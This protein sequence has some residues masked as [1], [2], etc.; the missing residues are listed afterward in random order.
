MIVY[1]ICVVV[2]N[3]VNLFIILSAFNCLH[4]FT[5]W[6]TNFLRHFEVRVGETAVEDDPSKVNELCSKFTANAEKYSEVSLKCAYPGIEGNVISV[7]ASNYNFAVLEI[8][9]LD[10]PNGFFYLNNQCFKWLTDDSLIKHHKKCDLLRGKLLDTSSHLTNNV[11]LA[12][13]IMTD[14][15]ATQIFNINSHNIEGNDITLK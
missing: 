15:S 3:V 2:K 6:G 5:G 14:Y 7:Y 10:C 8:E 1:C 13:K 9:V 11:K 12:L 4:S